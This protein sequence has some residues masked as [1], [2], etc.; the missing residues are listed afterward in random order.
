MGSFMVIG[1]S[2]QLDI[3]ADMLSEKLSFLLREAHFMT[4]CLDLVLYGMFAL[5]AAED[6]S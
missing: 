4:L 2:F 1:R 6:R 3:M 5:L